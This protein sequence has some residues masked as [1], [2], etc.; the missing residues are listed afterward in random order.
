MRELRLNSETVR[1]HGRKPQPHHV[2]HHRERLRSEFIPECTIAPW[3]VTPWVLV[4]TLVPIISKH[5]ATSTGN[6]CHVKDGLDGQLEADEGEESS[7][8]IDG[9]DQHV[10]EQEQF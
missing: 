1:E 5:R 7:E 10:L 8:P 4:N 9:I 2:V 3:F 6:L